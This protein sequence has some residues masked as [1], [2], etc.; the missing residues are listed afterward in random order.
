MRSYRL[1]FRR[2]RLEQS[3]SLQIV[4]PGTQIN[5]SFNPDLV[6]YLRRA[7]CGIFCVVVRRRELWSTA[8]R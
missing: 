5:P 8:K 3:V 2:L 1:V 4:H 7:S 6:L